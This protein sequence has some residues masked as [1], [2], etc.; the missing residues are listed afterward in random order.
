MASVANAHLE[1]ARK[2][3]PSVPA[4]ALPLLL[5]ARLLSFSWIP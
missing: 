4:E 1:K 5:P 2:L 3:A